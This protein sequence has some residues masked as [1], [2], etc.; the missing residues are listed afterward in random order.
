MLRAMVVTGSRQQL[1]SWLDSCK[2]TGDAPV[3]VPV[4]SL[5][6]NSPRINGGRWHLQ[7]EMA[8]DVGFKAR[9]IFTGA[10]NEKIYVKI[11]NLAIFP[12]NSSV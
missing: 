9:D 6:P 11:N 12:F 8:H 5:D 1:A 10:G 3:A 4:F 7:G 2:Y